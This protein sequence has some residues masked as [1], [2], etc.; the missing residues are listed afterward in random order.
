MQKEECIKE[1]N[2]IVEIKNR[3]K[4]DLD[5]VPQGNVRCEMNRGKY[6][7]YYHHSNEF[8]EEYPN[9]KYIKK[10]DIY[11][12]EQLAQRDYDIELLKRLN[13]RERALKKFVSSKS[14]Y[15]NKD[16]YDTLPEA[17]K[18]IITPYVQ[19]DEEFTSEW[20]ESGLDIKNDYVIASG[21]N[22][23]RG[24]LV[25]SKSEKMIADKLYYEGINYKYEQ[26]LRLKN[27]GIV[28]P[29]FTILNIRTRKTYYIEHF[30]MMDT[31]EYCKKALE[32]LDL[33]EMNDLVLGKN[34]FATFESSQK[35]LNMNTIASFI[36]RHF[37]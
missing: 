6:P 35:G 25:R 5:N 32:K 9:G 27:G 13:A 34:F 30:G 18:C 31:P 29:D 2:Q 19:T 36:E 24:E 3:I 16:L 15:D 12:A 22:T 23:E 28:Y 26:A 7:Q 8:K 1:L 17:K 33:Y 4:K 20:Y 14:I 11:L 37:K 21:Y 10:K